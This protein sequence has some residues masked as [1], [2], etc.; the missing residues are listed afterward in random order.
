MSASLNLKLG[1]LVTLA[2]LAGTAAV[3]VLGL[4]E[5]ASDTYHTYFDESVQ[6][7]ERGAVVKYRGVRIGKVTS[8]GVAPDRRLVDVELAINHASTRALDL[9]RTDLRAQLVVFG[10]TGVKLIDLDFANPNTPTPPRL[11]FTPP[12]RFIPSQPSLLERVEHGAISTVDRLPQLVDRGI[13]TLEKID[14]I[15]DEV[16]REKLPRRIGQLADAARIAARDAGKAMREVDRAFDAGR[17]DAT[18]GAL[19]RSAKQLE[20]FVDHVNGGGELERTLQDVG[21]AARTLRTFLD[22]LER[23]PDMLVKGRRARP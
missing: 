21:E 15:V 13:A 22:T 4:R 3:L 11:T 8:I 10:I 5:P 17:I 9:S 16:Q 20:A 12:A 1:L 19:Q 23:Q 18:L 2:V 14:Q 7:L 6:G